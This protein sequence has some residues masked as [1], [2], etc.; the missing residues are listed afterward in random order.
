MVLLDG[1]SLLLPSGVEAYTPPPP[2]ANAALVYSN[3][4]VTAV[5]TPEPVSGRHGIWRPIHGMIQTPWQT[6]LNTQALA[7]EKLNVGSQPGQ[8]PGPKAHH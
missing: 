5:P 8:L 2:K 1:G 7:A 4:G 3:S 6:D